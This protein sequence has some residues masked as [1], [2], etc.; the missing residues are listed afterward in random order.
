MKQLHVLLVPTAVINTSFL[1]SHWCWYQ[2]ESLIFLFFGLYLKGELD[3]IRSAIPIMHR[4][5]YDSHVPQTISGFNVDRPIHGHLILRS[6]RRNSNWDEIS[7]YTFALSF[8]IPLR[9]RA[10]NARFK[11]H[12]SQSEESDQSNLN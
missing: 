1:V 3:I 7:F 8:G 12:L 4:D 10:L 11:S 2:K 5:L 9:S 6:G